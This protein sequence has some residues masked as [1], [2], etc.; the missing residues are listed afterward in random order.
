MSEALPTYDE[1]PVIEGAPPGSSWGVWG[2]HDTL[3]ALNLQTPERAR[4]AA[5]SIRTGRWFALGLDLALPDPPL[6]RRAAFRHEVTGPLGGSHDD[7]LHGWNTQSSSQW[8]G[9]RHFAHPE[10]RHYGGVPDEQHGMD[11]WAARGIVGRAVLVDID[12]WRTAQGRPLRQG[13]PDPIAPA[14]LTACIDDQGTRLE[15]GDVLLLRTGWLTW[16]RAL[17]ADARADYAAAPAVRSP[18]PAGED[19][20]AFLWN[21]HISA[22][23]A[24]NPAVEMFPPDPAHHGFLH[25]IALPLLGLPLGELWD[26]D[27]LAEDCAAVG[28]YDAFFTSAPLHVRGGVASPPNAIAVR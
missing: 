20:P 3:G 14:D 23:G 1:L 8:D 12:R 27:A 24:D 28:T 13:T 18:G 22:I 2:D 4:R 9:F 6:F 21:L 19:L 17:D 26:L 10:H 5:A 7:L 16:Y 25:P 11:H 15:V